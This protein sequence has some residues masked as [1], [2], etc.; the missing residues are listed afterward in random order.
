MYTVFTQFASIVENAEAVQVGCQA[1]AEATQF[2][3]AERFL[4][5]RSIHIVPFSSEV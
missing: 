3:V 5:T 2:A 4:F 1:V